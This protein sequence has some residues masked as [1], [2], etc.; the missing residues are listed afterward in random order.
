MTATYK[1][2]LVE[3]SG[4]ILEC[5]INRPEIRNA[6]STEAE[7]EWDEILTR[8]GN[9][10]DIRVVTLMGEGK[11]FCA[12]ADL[13]EGGGS[14]RDSEGKWMGEQSTSA[15]STADELTPMR[16]GAERRLW[17][18][19]P[20]NV[21]YTLPNSWYFRKTLIAG[22]HGYVGELAMA[23]FLAT[24]DYI[25]A[26]EGTRFDMTQSRIGHQ[27]QP[28]GLMFFQ[29]PMRVLKQLVQLGGWFYADKALALDYV[30][31][32]VPL[33]DLAGEVRKWAENAAEIPNNLTSAYKEG[34]HRMYEIAGLLSM[35]G[36][37][38]VVNG[39]Q[40]GAGKGPEFYRAL[41]EGGLSSAL[42]L[43]ST[44][45]SITQIK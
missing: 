36:V 44:D 14:F 10:P 8:A 12:G 15:D 37:G 5:R 35:T 41:Q 4:H 26:A 9:D 11:V 19:E 22:V 39:H 34:I 29:F 24:F 18:P 20:M 28:V 17:P 6:L 30:Q 40:I 45:E 1:N 25:I 32:V 21:P 13:K 27:N 31:R 3:K 42:K 7:N 33:V 38:N 16:R 43:R 23:R 2:F